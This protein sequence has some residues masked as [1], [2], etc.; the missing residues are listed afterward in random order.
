[1]TWTLLTTLFHLAAYWIALI[2]VLAIAVVGVLYSP[3]G[4]LLFVGIGVGA[5]LTVGLQYGWIRWRP[6]VQECRN[7]A[8]DPNGPAC[9][10]WVSTDSDRGYGYWVTI[11]CP[12][13]R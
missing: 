1:M 9:R 2:V 12:D 10:K 5:L 11:P 6:E 4:K 3:I 7:P 13:S 8:Y